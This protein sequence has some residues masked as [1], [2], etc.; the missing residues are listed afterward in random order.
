MHEAWRGV[1]VIIANRDPHRTTTLTLTYLGHGDL[2]LDRLMELL[3]E[4]GVEAEQ[5]H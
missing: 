5:K 3:D 2:R 4:R 1:V